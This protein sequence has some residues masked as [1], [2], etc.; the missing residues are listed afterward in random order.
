MVATFL[1]ALGIG[2][3]T[4]IAIADSGGGAPAC[5]GGSGG[6]QTVAE[7]S[8]SHLLGVN[9]AIFGIVGYAAAARRALLRGD[10]ARMARLRARPDR[11]RLQRLPDLPGALRD[12]RDLPVVRGQ[13][14]AD[15][16]ALRGQRDPHG[17][18]TSGRPA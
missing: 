8:H 15:D 11:L 2:V 5:I 13:R 14:H 18:A 3:A 7:S 6:C 12:R 17:R 1:A 4:Y 16:A 9:V 10:G